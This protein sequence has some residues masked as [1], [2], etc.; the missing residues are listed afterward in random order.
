MRFNR[1][2]APLA[3]SLAVLKR[4]SFGTIL[5]LA[6]NFNSAA[7][8]KSHITFDAAAPRPC[9]VR[10]VQSRHGIRLVISKLACF[11]CLLRLGPLVDWKDY[12]LRLVNPSTPLQPLFSSQ[13]FV[14]QIFFRLITALATSI[15][16]DI[17]SSLPRVY[18]L[19]I[20]TQCMLILSFMPSNI[21]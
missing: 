5:A 15:N 19:G 3:T 7:S 9:E 11:S 1:V 21:F 6:P 18:R 10:V 14:G 2:D 16:V 17:L 8:W 4:G 20:R 13:L 12:E